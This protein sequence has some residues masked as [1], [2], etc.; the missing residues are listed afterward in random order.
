MV[1]VQGGTSYLSAYFAS[2]LIVFHRQG[3]EM[4]IVEALGDEDFDAYTCV[5][6]LFANASVQVAT[7]DVELLQKVRQLSA[8]CRL[9]NAPNC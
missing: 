2:N 7:N 8:R 9:P 5:M 6:P 4:P 3:P 1:A